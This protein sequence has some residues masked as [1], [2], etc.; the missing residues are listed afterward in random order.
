MVGVNTGPCSSGAR[1][2]TRAG[3]SLRRVTGRG[4]T[5]ERLPHGPHG[6]SREEVRASQQKRIL[7]AMMVAVGTH[8]YNDTT[9]AHVTAS[10]RVSRSAFYEQFTDKRDAFLTAY[11]DWGNRF[12]ADLLRAGERATSLREVISACGDV[13]V[14]RAQRE[15]EASRAF[16]LEVYA[17]GEPGLERREEMLRLGEALFDGLAADLQANHPDLAAPFPL[18]G[19]AVIGASFE[20]CAHVLRHPGA[21]ALEQVRRAIEDIW[22][23]GLTGT[24]DRDGLPSPG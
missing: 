7:D 15:P 4:A 10:A 21:G 17:T 2:R 1:R 16:I 18:A 13:L 12:F 14:D 24:S 20:L 6:L 5:V 9:V 11:S 8:G 19:L 23:V 22:F 3:G